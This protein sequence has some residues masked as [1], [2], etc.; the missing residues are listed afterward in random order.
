MI[1]LKDL[2]KEVYVEKPIAVDDEDL[3]KKG[4]KLGK[5]TVNPETGAIASDVTYLPEF[6]NVRRQVL[7]MRKEFQ[8]FNYS[9]NADVAKISKEITK[10]MTQISQLIFALDKTIELERKSR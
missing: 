7:K 3:M 10:H 8:P 9:S 6:E 4:F 1:K 5:P 2:L